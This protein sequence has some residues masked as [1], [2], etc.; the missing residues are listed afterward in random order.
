MEPVQNACRTEAGRKLVDSDWRPEKQGLYDPARE[1]DACGVGMCADLHGRPARSIVRNALQIL[2]NLDHRGAKGCEVDTGDGSGILVGMPDEFIRQAATEVG[3]ELPGKRQ[4]AV[5][6][7]FLAQEEEAA[8]EGKRIIQDACASVPGL[9]M[10]GWRFVPT[11]AD[12]LGRT[13]ANFEPTVEQ[14]F[15]AAE[16]ALAQ[17]VKKFEAALFILRRKATKAAN[18]EAGNPLY[19]CSLSPRVLTYKG[20]L[21]CAQIARYYPDLQDESF[22][23]H[24][25]L[26]HSRFSTNTFPAWRRSHPFRFLCHNGEINTLRGNVNALRSREGMFRSDVIG[27][28]L[29]E[30]FPIVEADQTDSGILDNALELMVLAGRPLREAMAILMPQAWEKSELVST[31]MKEYYKYHAAIM[32]PWDGPALV[33]FTDGDGVGATL[34]RNGLRPARYYVTKS[35]QVVLSSEAGVISELPAADVIKKGRL[36]P[37]KMLWA[38]FA[39][40]IIQEDSEIKESL[41]AAHPFGDWIK[42]NT[43]TMDYLRTHKTEMRARYPSSQ[44]L[45]SIR[46]HRGVQNDPSFATST[47]GAK[48]EGQSKRV[49]DLRAFGYTQESLD[50]LLLPMGTAGEEGLGRPPLLYTELTKR[51]TFM[52]NLDKAFD[53]FMNATGKKLLREERDLFRDVVKKWG[54]VTYRKAALNAD[55]RANQKA[56]KD[57]KF[58]KDK[59]LADSMLS[60][61]SAEERQFAGLLEAS[62]IWPQKTSKP[63]G[64]LANPTEHKKPKTSVPACTVLGALVAK[65][66]NVAKMYGLQLDDSTNAAKPPTPLRR[67]RTTSRTS[68]QSAKRAS[69]GSMKSARSRRSSS[70]TSNRSR[71]SSFHSQSSKKSSQRSSRRS[72]RQSSRTTSMSSARSSKDKR[73]ASLQKKQEEEEEF[74]EEELPSSEEATRRSQQQVAQQGQGQEGQEASFSL[75]ITGAEATVKNL[76]QLYRCTTWELNDKAKRERQRRHTRAARSR[77]PRTSYWNAYTCT[78]N[79]FVYCMA[80]LAKGGGVQGLKPQPA[81]VHVRGCKLDDLPLPVVNFLGRSDK[82]VPSERMPSYTEFFRSCTDFNADFTRAVAILKFPSVGYLDPLHGLRRRFFKETSVWQPDLADVPSSVNDY[83]Q[84]VTHDVLLA[85]H[86]CKLQEHRLHVSNISSADRWAMQW[87]KANEDRLI[88]L[89]TDKGLGVCMVSRDISDT[90]ARENLEASFTPVDRN[91]IDRIVS[92]AKFRIQHETQFG[93]DMHI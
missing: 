1:K 46:A 89:P 11:C 41:A 22:T 40:G 59:A 72:S 53:E 12:C 34:D 23:S 92:V 36:S 39:K 14:C 68:N 32:E 20:M 19:F 51:E 90:L 75:T 45:P 48:G 62:N 73:A 42:Q 76:K 13:A 16:G 25:A 50:L 9:K 57:E 30:C 43:M 80:K 21:T 79:P 28:E 52:T 26:V 47:L 93:I 38:D 24:V 3:I 70:A 31:K 55:D 77:R 44:G 66:P 91:E 63:D 58:K 49:H 4:Y 33:F 18:D 82:L 84:S 65:H 67:S 8:N 7:V 87:L 2:E 71:S 5:G 85:F 6:N 83:V 78:F 61:L 64:I 54:M 60:G 37:G 29:A 81:Q 17:D 74:A 88:D 10:L 35:G 27:P 86:R 56:E 15:I 69:S